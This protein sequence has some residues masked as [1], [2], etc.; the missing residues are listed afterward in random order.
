M[1][2]LTLNTKKD[3]AG[4]H[5]G[6]SHEPPPRVADA[7]RVCGRARSGLVSAQ[8]RS[9]VGRSAAGVDADSGEG[10]PPFVA[11]RLPPPEDRSEPLPSSIATGGQ[12]ARCPGRLDPTPVARSWIERAGPSRI[13]DI[14]GAFLQMQRLRL[15][16]SPSRTQGSGGAVVCVRFA[17]CRGCE[18]GQRSPRTR[19][20]SA[21][22]SSSS[23]SRRSRRIVPASSSA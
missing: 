12:I 15:G 1:V 23:S 22:P 6:R 4:V 19:S 5:E 17:R 10:I 3:R 21:A 2:L 7:A 13:R 8:A 20:M 16:P 11:R 14:R 18:A 9:P